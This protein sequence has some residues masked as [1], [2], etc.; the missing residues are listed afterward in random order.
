[1]KNSVVGLILVVLSGLIAVGSA[2]YFSET[3]GPL[4]ALI[5]V[6]WGVQRVT[7]QAS[8]EFGKP[9]L[10][11]L[12]IA[13]GY[14]LIALVAYYLRE[15]QVLWAMILVNWLGDALVR[16]EEPEV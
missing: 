8:Q 3:A 15:V 4:W 13:L 7:F 16:S 6:A 12:V 2:I 1:M 11:G 10:V 14:L 9:T 5:L